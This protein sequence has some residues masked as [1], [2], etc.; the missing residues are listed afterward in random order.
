[1]NG[2][3]Q[4]HL[5]PSAARRVALTP[6]SPARDGIRL[7]LVGDDTLTG[8]V[9]AWATV[10]RPRHRD[11]VEWTGTSGY[12]YVLPL[13]LDGTEISVGVDR[14]VEAECRTLIDW[15]A[16]PTKATS[17]PVVLVATGPLKTAPTTR[18]V[19]TDLAWGGQ[20]R[21]A[22]GKRVQQY[23]T[24]T[25]TEHLSATVRKS[26]AKKVRDKSGKD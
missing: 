18:W 14:T 15:A 2:G 10:N 22:N 16:K 26:P 11:A 1:M 9:G 25:L 5:A 20:I 12:T 3:T 7:D 13:L 6:V 21:N 24:V 17:Q 23:V 4:A 8:G 19:I